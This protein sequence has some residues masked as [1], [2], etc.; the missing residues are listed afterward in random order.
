MATVWSDAAKRKEQ[1]YK[2]QARVAGVGDAFNE[3]VG[4]IQNQD[5][6]DMR[7]AEDVTEN[8][9]SELRKAFP[10]MSDDE[11]RESLGKF[12]DLSM[13][14]NGSSWQSAERIAAAIKKVESNGRYNARGASG[15]RGAYQFMPSTWSGWAKK[16]L[17]DANAPMTQKNQDAVAIAKISDWQKQ[18]Y[19][20]E[21]IALMWNGGE[22]KRKAGI[23]SFGVRYDS[24]AY[25]DRV[26]SEL[27]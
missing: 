10:E 23:N 27:G 25:A 17:G 1:Q 12:N 21:Q 15:E 19:T 5:S 13:S 26:L 7:S 9:M 22:P 14:Q 11:I 4:G 2:S 3:F 8:E 6:V 20:P 18:G 24:G 16:Y